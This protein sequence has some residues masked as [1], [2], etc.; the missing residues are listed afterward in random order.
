MISPPWYGNWSV[1][2]L[3]R[4]KGSATDW[5]HKRS[6]YFLA[7]FELNFIAILCCYVRRISQTTSLLG[8]FAKFRKATISI[9][10]SLSL[11]LSPPVRLKK[12]VSHRSSFY[13]T[14]SLSIFRKSVVKIKVTLKSNNNSGTLHEDLRAFMVLSCWIGAA[15][16]SVPEKFGE[17]IKTRFLCSKTS[18][19]KSYRLWDNVK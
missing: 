13:G 17:T 14:W 16:R 4:P 19:Q 12:I 18:F 1:V 7:S 15:V 5:Y 11:S 10:T 9:D 6:P 8:A 3:P 2:L